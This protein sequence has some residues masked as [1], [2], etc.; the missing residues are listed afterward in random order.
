MRNE[1]TKMIVI[2]LYSWDVRTQDAESIIDF[3]MNLIEPFLSRLVDNK[4]RES[5]ASSLRVS[6]SQNN[7]AQR[8]SWLSGIFG[9]KK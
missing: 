8:Q 1:L 6:E 3:I 7:E 9:G 4:E 5:Y 2:N